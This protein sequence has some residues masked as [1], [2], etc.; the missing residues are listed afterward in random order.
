MRSQFVFSLTNNP[1]MM[2]QPNTSREVCLSVYMYS[3]CICMCVYVTVYLLLCITGYNFCIHMHL[4]E[5]L[6]SSCDDYRLP[7]LKIYNIYTFLE[8]GP[9]SGFC[10]QTK[11]TLYSFLHINRCICICMYIC[12][13]PYSIAVACI[14]Y[15]YDSTFLT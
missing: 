12:C 9:D 15:I 7:Y 1:N 2:L 13:G 6:S 11:V 4:R 5:I 3:V 10:M 14:Q 8:N